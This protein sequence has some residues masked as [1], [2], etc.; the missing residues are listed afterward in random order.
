MRISSIGPRLQAELGLDHD[1]TVLEA[2]VAVREP[3]LGR[4]EPS[5]AV[6]GGDERA[7]EHRR[8]VAAVRARV[9]PDAAADRAGDR[10]RELEAAEAGV[11]GA[12]QADRV[13]R[14]RAG[15]DRGSVDVDAREVSAEL[16][17]ECVDAGVGDEE[18]RA[19]TDHRDAHVTRTS[20][21]QELARPRPLSRD[22]R[23]PCA[24]PPVPSVV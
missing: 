19:E 7:L 16:E 20:P 8:E 13:R 22:V 2:G 6:D 17:N 1:L 21:L 11:A 4:G 9:H 24:C 18:V 14:A 23:R 15:A 12:V 10:A 5:A 3:E